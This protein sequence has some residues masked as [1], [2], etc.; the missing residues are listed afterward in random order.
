M[1]HSRVT[2]HSPLTIHN[3]ESLNTLIEY[4]NPAMISRNLRK[5]LFDYLEEELKIGTTIYFLDLLP[6][7]NYLFNLLEEAAEA[8]GRPL[9]TAIKK[10]MQPI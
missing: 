2:H 6:Q 9:S 10:V 8:K 1:H 5:V 3:M 4:G 7:L